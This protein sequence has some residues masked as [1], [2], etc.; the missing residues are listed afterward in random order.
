[1]GAG[2]AAWESDFI[3]KNTIIAFSY[4]GE[5]VYMFGESS[6]I[7]ITYSD[8]YGNTGG[9]WIGE[10]EDMLG[11]DGNIN[12]DPLFVDTT[13]SDYRIAWGSPCIDTGDPNSGL[14][15]DSTQA[16]MGAYFYDHNTGIDDPHNLPQVI[17][18]HQN[19]PNPFN[20]STAISFELDK[21]M[22]ARLEIYDILGNR[23]TTL[24]DGIL[25]AGRHQV[26][27][28]ANVATGIYFYRL[29]TNDYSS[30]KKMLL[31]K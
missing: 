6:D 13:G 1:M 26:T 12:A 18:L 27:W 25:A 31:V 24:V 21:R 20:A 19:Y 30:T 10:L 14:D 22:P 16:D 9:D 15:P 3:L 23:V 29:T 8:I 2:I 7:A 28:H 5:G 4:E 11:V 17:S